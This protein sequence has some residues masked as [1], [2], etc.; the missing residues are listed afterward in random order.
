M[1]SLLNSTAESFVTRNSSKRDHHIP[2]IPQESGFTWHTLVK[3][4]EML[5]L[6]ALNLL[7]YILSGHYLLNKVIIH[8][9]KR[10]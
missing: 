1:D 10:K 2:L 3:F 4:H 9:R 8:K 7:S 5:R 6:V